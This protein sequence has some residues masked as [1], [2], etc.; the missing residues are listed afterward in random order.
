MKN[1]GAFPFPGNLLF[2]KT[3]RRS[4]LPPT[5]SQWP[6]EELDIGIYFEFVYCAL[7][8]IAHYIKITYVRH[9]AVE[10]RKTAMKKFVS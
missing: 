4:P 9:S 5:S 6:L 7:L 3:R 1:E 10:R 8:T 2:I